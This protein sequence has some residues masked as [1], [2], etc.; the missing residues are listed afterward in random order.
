[1]GVSAE[2]V[3]ARGHLLLAD[4]EALVVALVPLPRQPAL[5]Q[6]EEG[7]RQRLKVIAAGRRAPEV[8]VHARVAHSAAEDVRALVV[9]DVRA[10]DKV[11]PPSGC[12]YTQAVLSGRDQYRTENQWRDVRR[13]WCGVGWR[14]ATVAQ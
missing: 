10:A 12:M 6:E 3:C 4:E 11:L 14:C 8:R 1:M 13:T 7:V 5:E 2:H 9:L